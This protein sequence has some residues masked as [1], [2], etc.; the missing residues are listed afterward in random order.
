M[1]LSLCLTS[2]MLGQSPAKGNSLSA[3]DRRVAV[4][5]L[6]QRVIQAHHFALGDN[7]LTASSEPVLRWSNPTAG[8]V[9]GDVFVWTDRGR[10]AM[11]A[12]IFRWFQPDWG[13]TL[14][15]CSLADGEIIGRR[16][17]REFWHPTA[18]GIEWK[19]IAE[20]PSVA[21]TPAARLSQMKRLA[22]EVTATLVDHRNV[23]EP[24]PR[25]LRLMPQPVFRYP[26]PEDKSDYLDGSL[27]TFVEG[28]DPEVWLL[29]EA[30]HTN[31]ESR[32]RYGLARMNM[33]EVRVSICGNEAWSAPALKHRERL[34]NPG[35]PYGLFV[36]STN[37]AR[38]QP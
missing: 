1:W 6:A 33:D 18:S 8:E 12:S 11:V 5:E 24:V 22:N 25:M 17:E 36:L 34:N 4:A 20:P 35:E 13:A 16:G 23:A 29:V 28:T 30:L 3:E 31:D 38:V 19:S 21:N 7:T 10:P 26:A 37:T 2:L 27:F 15:L 9:Y 14:E 32:W